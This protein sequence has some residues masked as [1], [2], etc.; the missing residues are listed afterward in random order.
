ML[1]LSE[2][3]ISIIIVGLL[4]AEDLKVHDFK[5]FAQVREAHV[6]AIPIANELGDWIQRT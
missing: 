2:L 1:F 4:D 6:E 3:K 5:S